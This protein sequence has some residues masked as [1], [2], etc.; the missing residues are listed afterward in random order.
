[1]TGQIFS[2]LMVDVSQKQ[3]EHHESQP[4]TAGLTI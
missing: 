3:L 4:S 2:E 1:L